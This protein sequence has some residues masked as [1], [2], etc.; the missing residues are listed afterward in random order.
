MRTFG[1][2]THVLFAVAA[3]VGVIAALG[4]PWYAASPQ[5]VE[6]RVGMRGLL[7]GEAAGFKAGIERLISESGGTTGWDALGTWGTVI[8]VLAAFSAACALCCLVPSAQ[9]VAREGVRYSA[10]ACIAIIVW[11]LVDTPGDNLVLELRFGSLVAA[12][13]ALVAFTSGT[14]IASTSLRRRAVPAY[15]SR[16]LG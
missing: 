1:F 2:R 8:G 9:G 5:A 10:F 7:D 11:K 15:A 12:G 4:Q 13:A 16:Q 3:A 6:E 14:A